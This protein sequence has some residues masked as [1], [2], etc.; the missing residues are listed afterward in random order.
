MKYMCGSCLMPKKLRVGRSVGPNIKIRHTT[1][2][3]HDGL[4]YDSAH[5]NIHVVQGSQ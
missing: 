3:S 1:L 5:V 4:K 2:K